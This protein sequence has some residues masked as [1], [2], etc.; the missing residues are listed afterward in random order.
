[1]S[2]GRRIFRGNRSRRSVY[3]GERE[4]EDPQNMAGEMCLQHGL[5]GKDRR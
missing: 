4:R 2:S 3:R 1:M 5:A